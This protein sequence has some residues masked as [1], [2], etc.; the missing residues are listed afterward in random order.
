MSIIADT[1][2]R[3]QAQSEG[4]SPESMDASSSRPSFNKGEGSGRHRKDYPFGFFMVM[5]GMAITLASLAF[6]AFWIGEYLDFRLATNTQARG[7]DHRSIPKAAHLPE[8]PASVDESSETLV[9]ATPEPSQSPT[10]PANTEQD[11]V[12]TKVVTDRAPIP[13]L[14]LR[15]GITPSFYEV[16]STAP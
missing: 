6:A 4:T 5:V 3:L 15:E 10:T 7:N 8:D 9:A 2:K 11:Q 13:P 1:L 14:P 12:A 16:E